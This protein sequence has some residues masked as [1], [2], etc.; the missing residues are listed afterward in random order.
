MWTAGKSPDGWVQQVLI[1]LHLLL[2]IDSPVIQHLL[3]EW[4]D[5]EEKI[6]YLNKWCDGITRKF[7]GMAR[8]NLSQQGIEL[9]RL[10]DEVRDGFLKLL[11]PLLQQTPGVA[12]KAYVRQEPELWSGLRL[13]AEVV[14][15]ESKRLM[16]SPHRE[17]SD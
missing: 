3:H 8:G 12:I 11:V 4:T 7:D 15:E 1:I 10:S 2:R 14:G 17:I 9:A 5:D 16:V 13:R 6:S